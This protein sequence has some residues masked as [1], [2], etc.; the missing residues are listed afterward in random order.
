M[1]DREGS[2]GR[3]L[4][5]WVVWSARHARLVVALAFGL[6]VPLLWYSY[7]HLR[8]DADTRN[9]VS[10]QLPWRQ[11]HAALERA[12]P[13]LLD[14]IQIVIDA[15]SPEIA[16][17]AQRRLAEDLAA[18]TD[19]FSFVYAPDGGEFFERHG[20]LY[21]G[22][23]E[24]EELG[25]RMRDYRWMWL[26]LE[27]EP[28]LDGLASA[29]NRIAATDSTNGLH[30]API[31]LAVGGAFYSSRYGYFFTFPWTD[32][33]RGRRAEQA[34][35]RR[36]ILAKPILDYS[37]SRP[38][39]AAMQA[40]RDGAARLD[41][42][43]RAVRVRITGSEA[44]EHESI[45]AGL[46]DVPRLLVGALVMVAIV[47]LAFGLRIY[48][49][50]AQSLWND[51]GTSVALAR[52]DLVTITRDAAHDI[53]PPLYYYLLHLWVRLAGTT[54]FAVRFMSLLAGVALVACVARMSSR[55]YG[56]IASVLSS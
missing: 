27:E 5:A 48:R 56:S 13:H 8:V 44:F 47:L 37:R 10:D 52:R 40:I 6:V 9:L 19:L 28:T 31:L 24:L 46:S 35:L 32:L 51:E 30:V 21:S 25:S 1:I 4:G 11:A 33:M 41:L 23:E 26:A 22:T 18:R 17:E 15:A 7:T 20:F 12:L 36:F 39:A 45:D 29:V 16:A 14:D 54:E 34:Q 42:D 3:Q 50:D 43:H 38:A 2:L 53:H 49:L 55:L